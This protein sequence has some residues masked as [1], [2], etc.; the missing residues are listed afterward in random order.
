MKTV[1]CPQ[2]QA[3]FILRC[4]EFKDRWKNPPTD[5]KRILGT[6]LINA[7]RSQK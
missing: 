3:E 6:T 4:K 1:I 7:Q 2:K 5:W